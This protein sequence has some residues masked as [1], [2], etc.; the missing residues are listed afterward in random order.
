MV[1]FPHLLIGAAI[2]LRLPNFLAVFIFGLAAHFI[3][4]KIPHWD[5]EEQKMTELNRRDFFYFMIKVS[6][7]LI[8]GGSLLFFLLRHQINWPY[9]L[10]GALASA[11]PDLPIFLRHFFPE[12][13]WLA[14]YQELHDA[15]H[16]FKNPRQR[17]TPLLIS[18]VAV[19]AIAIFFLRI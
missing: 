19:V 17:I 16:L 3:A 7:D 15:N 4:D 11:L 8:I 14:A 6:L 12:I 18:E 13:K 5:Y 9:A 2:G 10:V 1:I